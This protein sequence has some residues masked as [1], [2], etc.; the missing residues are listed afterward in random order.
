MDVL[1]VVCVTIYVPTLPTSL[2]C[3]LITI[4]RKLYATIR[5]SSRKKGKYNLY[6]LDG[7]AGREYD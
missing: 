6:N 2:R 3:Y 5:V 1:N 4:G 7:I